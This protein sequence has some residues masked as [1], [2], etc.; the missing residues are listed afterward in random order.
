M[1]RMIFSSS[2]KRLRKIHLDFTKMYVK[3]LGIQTR[4][5]DPDVLVESGS[6]CHNTVG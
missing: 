5:S 1:K 6:G 3:I 2:K 4:V